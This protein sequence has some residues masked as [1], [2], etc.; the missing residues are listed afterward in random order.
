MKIK[1][2]L[3]KAD[4]PTENGV[5]YTKE[6]IKD[7]VDKFNEDGTVP[8]IWSELGSIES[9]VMVTS[10]SQAANGDCIYEAE[11]LDENLKRIIGTK[12]ST[13]ADIAH[14]MRS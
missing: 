12:I 2:I 9:K 10:L 5:V 7:V 3:F 14:L 1:G 11:V 6:A 8:K 13:K 4:D